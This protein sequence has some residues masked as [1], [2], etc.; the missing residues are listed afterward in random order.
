M[1]EPGLQENSSSDEIPEL[2]PNTFDEMDLD[3]KV[4]QAI[5]ELGY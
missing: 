5:S 4:R 3:P 2:L 1:T